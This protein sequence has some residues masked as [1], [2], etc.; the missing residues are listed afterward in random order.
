MKSR[1][2]TW[3]VGLG[4]LLLCMTAVA[5]SAQAPATSVTL[6]NS[7]RVLV[8]RTMTMAIPAGVSSQ[9]F[10]LGEFNPVTFA[11]LDPGVQLVSVKSDAQL[12]EQTL[13]R[14]YVGRAFEID[15]GRAG[16]PSRRATLLSMDPER[17]EWADR[18][19]VVFGHPGRVVW[20]KDLVPSLMSADVTLQSDR[21]RQS[22]K[23][24]YETS[25]SA[26]AT[27]YRLYLGASGR[28]EGVASIASGVL[29]LP[30]AEVQ[31]LSGDIGQGAPPS[32]RGGRTD[33]NASYID[34][35]PAMNGI[36]STNMLLSARGGRSAESEAAGEGHLYTLPSRVTFVPGSSIVVPLFDPAP[37]KADRRFTV[38]GALNYYGGFGQQPD[39]QQVPV[40]VAYHLDRKAGTTF[41]DLPLPGGYVGIFDLDKSGRVQL[42]GQGNIQHTAAGAELLVESGSAFDVTA[43]RVQTDFSTSR[44]LGPAGTPIGTVAL[45]SYRVTLQNAKDSAVMVEVR[46]DRSGEWSVIQSSIPSEKR[47]ATR[48]VFP[49]TIPAKG[50][51]VLTYRVRVVW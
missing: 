32:V 4:G 42:V 48:V 30:D 10:A 23:I 21:A 47:S 45:A 49:V 5:V 27:S 8:R 44:N 6:F 1:L 46:E 3:D 37:A 7:G 19:G 26:W 22:I 33:Q 18:A 36:A 38:G 43:K 9:T 2:G 20:P 12:N 31:L 13:L 39:E 17:W 14:R 41:G 34:G 50:T 51:V 24:M 28:I 35:V 40:S 15:T 11:L 25:G 16:A 29:Q